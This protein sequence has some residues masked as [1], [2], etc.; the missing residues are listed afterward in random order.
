VIVAEPTCP[1]GIERCDPFSDA[2]A[3][4]QFDSMALAV[5][6]SYSLYQLESVERPSMG[7]IK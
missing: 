6:K 3:T 2:S 7:P 4:F 1:T 5:I